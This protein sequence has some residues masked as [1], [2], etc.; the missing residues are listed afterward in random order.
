MRAEVVARRE[1]K[2][3]EMNMATRWYEGYCCSFVNVVTEL[4]TDRD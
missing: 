4:K 3:H 2:M 1:R